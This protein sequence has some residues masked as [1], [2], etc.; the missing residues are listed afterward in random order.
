M[1]VRQRRHFDHGHLRR[2]SKL[3]CQQWQTVVP[4]EAVEIGKDV[5]AP[6]VSH[7]LPS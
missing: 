5:D 4:C 1:C 2:T 6:L 7:E 3:V